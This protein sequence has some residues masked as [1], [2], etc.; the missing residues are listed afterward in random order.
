[1]EKETIRKTCLQCGKMISTTSLTRRYCNE[2]CKE[3]Y[4]QR[5]REQHLIAAEKSKPRYC[6]QCG[7]PLAPNRSKYC[8]PLCNARHQRMKRKQENLRWKAKTKYEYRERRCLRCDQV[9]L[10]EGPHNRL[11]LSC[12]RSNINIVEPYRIAESY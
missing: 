9:F 3:R 6:I 1:M 8:S 2:V 11:C 10:S 5:Q 12:Q 7:V 4:K